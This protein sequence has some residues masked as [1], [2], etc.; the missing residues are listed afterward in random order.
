MP[1]GPAP[2]IRK[3]G[4]LLSIIGLSST[5]KSGLLSV[6]FSFIHSFK[7]ILY[8]H[9]SVI[10][11]ILFLISSL[12]LLLIDYKYFLYH[13]LEINNILDFLDFDAE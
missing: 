3:F 10:N 1:F 7:L 2:N 12:V 4:L 9:F 13:Y 5:I 6:I 11:L 8:E